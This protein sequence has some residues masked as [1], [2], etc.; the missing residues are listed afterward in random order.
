[1][2]NQNQWRLCYPSKLCLEAYIVLIAISRCDYL[3]WNTESKITL[4]KIV[5]MGFLTQER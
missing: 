4:I 2:P 5:V 1:M 3:A